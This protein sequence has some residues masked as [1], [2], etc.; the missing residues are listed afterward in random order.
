MRAMTTV[1]ISIVEC[2]RLLAIATIL[3]RVA[4]GGSRAV[5]ARA[6]AGG[7]PLDTKIKLGNDLI[8]DSS[9][10]ERVIETYL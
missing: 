7:G 4:V 2:T 3:S 8:A 5:N 1:R 6:A 10:P 9:P